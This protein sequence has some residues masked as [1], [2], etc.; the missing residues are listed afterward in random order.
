MSS[1]AQVADVGEGPKGRDVWLDPSKRSTAH[2][3]STL[4]GIHGLLSEASAL[5]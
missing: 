4:Q 5:F 2:V 1:I 3:D